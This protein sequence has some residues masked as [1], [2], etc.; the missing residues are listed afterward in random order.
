MTQ[1]SNQKK[2]TK[3]SKG[4]KSQGNKKLQRTKKSRIRHKNLEIKKPKDANTHTHTLCMGFFLGSF[5][6]DFRVFLV[7]EFFV[8]KFCRTQG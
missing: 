2:K 3:A 6:F 5:V 8:R 1:Q 4:N 7:C